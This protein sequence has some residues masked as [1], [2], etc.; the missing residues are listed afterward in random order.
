M[1]RYDSAVG[2]SKA[3]SVGSQGGIRV[4]RKELGRRHLQ[5]HSGG[6]D[7]QDRWVVLTS[8][9]ILIFLKGE[10]VG[11]SARLGL[12]RDQERAGREMRVAQRLL[13]G[14]SGRKTVQDED[15]LR[16]R[17]AVT[18]TREPT[19]LPL[20]P[21]PLSALYFEHPFHSISFPALGSRDRAWTLRHHVA[22]TAWR[23]EQ[24]LRVCGRH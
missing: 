5:E 3:Q 20:S 17:P 23:I 2:P 21:R 24:S 7:G 4:R 8:R 11:F 18:E 13:D 15:V 16:R 19:A 9:Q 1:E 6:R 12:A 10:A 14:A 22:R